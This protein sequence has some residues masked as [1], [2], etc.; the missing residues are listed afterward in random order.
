MNLQNKILWPSWNATHQQCEW[1]KLKVKRRKDGERGL[2]AT[3]KLAAKTLIPFLGRRISY[4]TCMKGKDWKYVMQESRDVYLNG[5]PRFDMENLFIASF[6][7]EPPVRKVAN[8]KCM[9]VKGHQGLFLMLVQDVSRG[10]EITLYYGS[11]YKR[12]GYRCGKECSA[13]RPQT[14][15]SLSEKEEEKLDFLIKRC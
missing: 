2:F 8:A 14:F 6:V 7:N 3:H 15:V 9:R 10:T 12:K 4:E 5:D 13:T 11:S 1:P